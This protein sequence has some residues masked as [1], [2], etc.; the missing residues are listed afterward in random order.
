[1][2]EQIYLTSSGAERMGI[3]LDDLVNVRRPALAERLRAAIQQGDLSENAD[4][5]AAKEE[6][7]FLEGRI[8]ELE[9]LL[10]NAVII[11]ENVAERDTVDLGAKVTVLVDEDDPETYLL[12]GAK[13]ASPRD[14]RISNESPIGSALLGH[15]VGDVVE[16][17]TPGGVVRIKIV[18]ID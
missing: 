11:E 6:Q 12:V 16:A 10:A 7:G 14:G 9:Y 1:M 2:S 13:E 17:E 15:K 8:Q 3:E 4:Y 18:Q 5:K